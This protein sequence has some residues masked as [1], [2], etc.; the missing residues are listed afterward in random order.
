MIISQLIARQIP[1]IMESIQI[2]EA[3]ISKEKADEYR[4][5][6]NALLSTLHLYNLHTIIIIMAMPKEPISILL[7]LL[8]LLPRL[9]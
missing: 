7:I 9:L 4:I 3:L 1:E 5:K 8:L 6:V 2:Y